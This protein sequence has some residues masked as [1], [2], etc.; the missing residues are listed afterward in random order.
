MTSFALRR[1]YLVRHGETDWNREGRL[2][3]LTDSALNEVGRSQ[4][5]SLADRLT[6]LECDALYTS[7]LLRAVETAE[8]LAET[9]HR[10]PIVHHGLRERDVGAWGGMT[11]AEVRSVYPDEWDRSVAGEDVAIGGGESK[12]IVQ[13]RMEHALEQIGA[14]H[15]G[16]SVVVVSHGLALKTLLCGLIGLDLRHSERIAT[17]ANTSL[18]VFENRNGAPRLTMLADTAHLEPSLVAR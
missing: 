13:T 6:G 9:L 7:P 12:R 2:Q 1:L 5:R 17:G 4:A 18:T 10:T 14:H 8:F 3:G 11:Y 15:A 16:G